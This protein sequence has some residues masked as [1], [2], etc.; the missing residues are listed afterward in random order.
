M[1]AVVHEERP[2]PDADERT[3]IVVELVALAL[4][5]PDVDEECN[6]I[7]EGGHSLLAVAI[8]EKLAAEH[9]F[10]LDLDTLYQ[11][12]LAQAAATAIDGSGDS[13]S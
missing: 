3:R 11:G 12:T 2:T 5:A 4:S 6:F 8:S 13:S 10:E 1:S 9:G 7:E